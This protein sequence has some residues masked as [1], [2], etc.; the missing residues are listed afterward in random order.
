MNSGRFENQFLIGFFISALALVLLIFFPML[1]ALVLGVSLAILFHP[2]YIK[3]LKMIP[4]WNGASALVTVLLAVVIIFAPLIFFGFQIFEEAR[5][6][7]TSLVSGNSSPFV[8][9]LHGQFQK[10]TPLINVD[11]KQYLTQ[12]LGLFLDN[13]TLIFSKLINVFFTLFFALFTMYY[14]LKDGAKIKDTILRI[15]PL[16]QTHSKE[17]LSKLSDMERSTMHGT[18]VVAVAQGILVGLG[19]F[20]F[21]LSSPVLWGM[22]AIFATAKRPH[23]GKNR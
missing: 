12:I 22:V 11:I 5:G 13:F 1:N 8:G 20:I 21:G 18:L 23:Q 19:F 6:L 4:R 15:S 3:L 2:V 17:I 14:L 9:L 10:L 7:Y 16:S